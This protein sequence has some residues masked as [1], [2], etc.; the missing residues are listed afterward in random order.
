MKKIFSILVGAMMMMQFGVASAAASTQMEP[1][2]AALLGLRR[3][4]ILNNNSGNDYINNNFQEAF[5]QAKV[6]DEAAMLGYIEITYQQPGPV[7]CVMEFGSVNKPKEVFK[8]ECIDPSKI[9]VARGYGVKI[10]ST[11]TPANF[12]NVPNYKMRA[13]IAKILKSTEMLLKVREVMHGTS[14]AKVEFTLSK[15][16]ENAMWK[17]GVSDGKVHGLHIGTNA[18]FP[19]SELVFEGK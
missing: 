14:Q 3:W 4:L 2:I 19:D 7:N 11:L 8:V 16:G 6:W 15:D 10:A 13:V 9:N 1:A 5:T 18:M 12:F 17:W